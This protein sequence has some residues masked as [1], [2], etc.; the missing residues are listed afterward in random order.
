MR[1]CYDQQYA[2]GLQPAVIL[3]RRHDSQ[4]F[5]RFCAP[6]EKSKAFFVS[7]KL[8]SLIFGQRLEAASRILGDE[9]EQYK[10]PTFHKHR[11]ELSGQ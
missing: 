10:K 11:L 4:I 9:I 5:E 3:T 2:S 1:I 7:L 6:F 8:Q